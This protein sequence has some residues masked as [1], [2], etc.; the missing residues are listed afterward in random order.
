MCKKALLILT[1][2]LLCFFLVAQHAYATEASMSH[3]MDKQAQ[4]ELTPEEVAWLAEHPV[5]RVTNEM[6]WPPFD[7]SKDGQP[8]GYSIDYLKLLAEATGLKLQFVGN[9][10][11]SD[12]INMFKRREVDV[13]HPIYLTEERKKIT[14]YCDKP[15]VRVPTSIYALK[16]NTHLR[17]LNDL[18]GKTVAMGEGWA[19]TEKMRKIHPE[20]IIKT[21]SNT[22]KMLKA[23]A[24]G[25]VDAAIESL[26]VV[27]YLIESE[28]LTNIKQTGFIQI[29][30]ESDDD[31]YIGVR[32]DWPQLKSIFDKAMCNLP[33]EKILQ[34]R[35]KWFGDNAMSGSM[36]LNETE[37]HFLK[38][39]PII[40]VHN[41]MDWPPFNFNVDGQPMGLTIDLMN[42]MA[43]WAG[44][45]V[46][47]VFDKTWDELENM[48]KE[49]QIDVMGNMMPTEGRKGYVQF[50]RPYL[51]LLQGFTVKTGNEDMASLEAL[52]GE[53]LAVVKG[54]WYV[55]LLR[56]HYPEINLLLLDNVVDCLRAVLDERAQACFGSVAVMNYHISERFMSELTTSTIIK[57]PLFGDDI[58]LA[59]GIRKDW[60]ILRDI[61]CKALTA[62]RLSDLPKIKDKWL[63]SVNVIT[64][65]KL[66]DEEAHHLAG[67]EALIFCADPNWMP[68]EAFTPEGKFTGISSDYLKLVSKRIGISF[69]PLHT[70]TW[71]ESLESIRN[72]QCDILPSAVHT[73]ERSEYLFFTEPYIEHP[74]VVATKQDQFYVGSMEAL[75]GK[76]VGMVR[77]YAFTNEF[78]KD[79]PKVD[80][81]EVDNV[82]EGLM[83]L[84]KGEF[85][86]F[87]DAVATIGYHVRKEGLLDLK[88]AGKLDKSWKLGMG[89]RNDDPVL[90]SIM[91][92][93]VTSITD[94]EK[95]QIHNKW[96]ALD[97]ETGVSKKRIFKW[98]MQVGAAVALVL[99]L[100]L[101]WNWRMRK[102]ID[103]RRRTE[104]KLSILYN[105]S[106]TISQSDDMHGAIVA[107]HDCL[108]ENMGIS[109]F[110]LALWN[111]EEETFI[112]P[113][114]WDASDQSE[115]VDESNRKEVENLALKV[116]QH[117]KPMVLHRS[118]PVNIP[119]LFVISKTWLL[120]PL[121]VNNEVIGGMGA[122]IPTHAE[123][124][125]EKGLDLFA[126]ISDNVAAG[127]ER[128]RIE[129]SLRENQAITNTLF[130]IASTVTD[131]GGT[132]QAVE[133]IH[134]TLRE[135]LDVNNFFIALW[136][137]DKRQ[138]RYFY[139]RDEFDDL[140]GKT[141]DN[142]DL[143]DP[144]SISTHVVANAKPLLMR[145]HEIIG[146]NFVGSVCR[147][148]LGVPLIIDQE[149]IGVMAV[150]DYYNEDRYSEKDVDFMVAVS[151][152]VAAVINRKMTEEALLHAQ[153]E[154]R[155]L[156]ENVPVGIYQAHIDGYFL[157]AN[158]EIVKLFGYDSVDQLLSEI[159]NF[160]NQIYMNPSN[161]EPVVRQ[162]REKGYIN[163]YEVEFVRRDGTPFWVSLDSRLRHDANG[164]SVI[165]DGHM[166]D[167]TERKMMHE[168]LINEKER[169]ERAKEEALEATRAK[170]DFL[171]RMSHEI[172][173]PMNAIIG[174]SELLTETTLTYD[175]QDFIH[176]LQSSCEILL[177][178]INDI[179]DFSKIEA[180]QIELE[181]TPFDLIDVMEGTGRILG[182]RARE[183]GLELAYHVAPE[184]H[185]YV[186]GDLTR[187]KQILINL[188]GNA[189][190]F[191]SEGDVTLHIAPGPDPA[192]DELILFS[193]S[194]T[195]IGI[196]KDKHE[197]IFDSFSQ[198]DTST[199]RKYGGTGLGLAISRRLTELMGGEMWIESE[200]N[201]GTI[202]YFTLRLPH[203]ES[204]PASTLAPA[205]GILDL[206]Q[207][208]RILVVDDNST[209]RLLL[210]DHLTRW[211]AMVDLAEDG[212]TALDLIEQASLDSQHY[213]LVF[214]DVIMPGIDGLEVAAK[215]KEHYPKPPPHIIINTS[216]DTYE[217]R[218]KA[219]ELELDWMLPKPVKRVDLLHLL[220]KLLGHTQTEIFSEQAIQ[221]GFENLPAMKL[222]LAEDIAPNRKVIHKYLKT[223]PFTITD[224]ENGQMAVDLYVESHG[225]YDM[226]LMDKEMPI[227]DG[228]TAISQIREFELEHKTKRVP[229]IALTAHAYAQDKKECFEAGCDE[230]MS[231]PV[232]KNNLLRGILKLIGSE[233]NENDQNVAGAMDSDDSK[234][235]QYA[236]E[237]LIVVQVDTDMEDLIPEFLKDL[238][239]EMESMVSA[240]RSG[241]FNELHRLAHGYKGAA[242]NY[243]MNDLSKIYLA[244]EKAAKDN[245]HG[246]SQE[247]LDQAS[248][249]L[250]RMRVEYV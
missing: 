200:E 207:S 162:L 80:F 142:V 239:E 145:H 141:L 143:N 218:V 108:R 193:V 24:V 66:T 30:S 74:I 214:L 116:I 129:E 131:P 111:A 147:I 242:G 25:D 17:S 61:M 168:A 22:L 215:I 246:K 117:K 114:Y 6:D 235:H 202:F 18:K 196:P 126:A 69:K 50:T 150:Q 83:R 16:G 58:F 138:L 104:Q 128:K 164:N 154:L 112:F 28:M 211:G 219:K 121:M 41:E 228:L 137:K 88:I 19:S 79:Y 146:S 161:R 85:D 15:M 174:M 230:F 238:H 76:T 2:I 47:Y 40:R 38:E 53:T 97:V 227:M 241:D 173:T 64:Q 37:K 107:I 198:A 68:N 160:A 73:P 8:M 156:F 204:V 120:V 101:F 65:L 208:M 185:R 167:I 3:L 210:H 183:K 139:H 33:Q 171:A 43:D 86:A 240:L 190:K 184:V 163:E 170:S 87:I 187:L 115:E 157:S 169:A 71:Y 165:I 89:V 212:E 92:K 10:K 201:K 118:Q 109:S 96:V 21:Y 77:G 237:G 81:V 206:F 105:V 14:L 153:E 72:R 243:G 48:L 54:F 177:S 135:F 205:S 32:S 191:T 130:R 223:T 233:T 192:D 7:F 99:G 31:L 113:Y 62:V 179:L 63:K 231:K 93:A 182:G 172:R 78:I 26:P 245:S 132:Y 247:R 244:L 178:I 222:L 56:E 203:V 110:F 123:P 248:D 57:T 55:P 36:T 189:I 213:T 194:D 127:I 82:Q 236:G 186:S 166:L 152:S 134:A 224:A 180:G 1:L 27:N 70:G 29:S 209:N 84:H 13:L 226:I 136:D 60:P 51:N 220:S 11:W 98:G 197:V 94:E 5:I 148:W 149:C 100:I 90:F 225:D 133:S 91:N 140:E 176:T 159:T 158:P 49:Q 175:Q 249:Y 155:T 34:L 52:D 124:A 39:H 232:K 181:E 217:D 95:Q 188:I 229:I 45:K 234:V 151:E 12:L 44:F 144:P 42:R 119:T 59:F 46:E 75:I 195:G 9:R 125:A 216:S 199:T 102:E 106:S 103:K 221:A 67:R 20:I 4:L 35:R 23:L 122:Q 250:V